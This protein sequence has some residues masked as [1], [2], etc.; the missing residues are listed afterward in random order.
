MNNHGKCLAV[1]T[2]GTIKP[3]ENGAKIIQADCDPSEKGQLWT[4]DR[5][6]K[7]LCNDWNKCLS[8]PFNLGGGLTKDVFHWDLIKDERR[9]QWAA[10]STHQFVNVG[11]CLAFEGN[12][13]AHG[14]RA[15]TN[16]CKDSDKGQIWTFAWY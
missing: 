12:S 5:M 10:L 3:S 14:V 7:L 8:V 6:K 2:T 15:I 16:Y 9:Q 13:D 11:S 4:W 1:E